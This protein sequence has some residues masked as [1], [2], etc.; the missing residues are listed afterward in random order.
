MAS[1]VPFD[2]HFG[3]QVNK[4]Q[5]RADLH[6]W[7]VLMSQLRGTPTGLTSTPTRLRPS[8]LAAPQACDM[9]TRSLGPLAWPRLTCT[10]ACAPRR[11]STCAVSCVDHATP[12]SGCTGSHTGCTQGA[13]AQ[14]ALP[15]ATSLSASSKCR[16]GR[17]ACDA[18]GLRHEHMPSRHAQAALLV[19]ATTGPV[20]R[21]G[22]R[23]ATQEAPQARGLSNVIVRLQG[24]ESTQAAGA[25]AVT[26][27]KASHAPQ[28][29]ARPCVRCL[30]PLA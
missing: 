17:R 12:T 23:R 22:P 3:H 25:P 16:S 11:H 7:H 14:V 27:S 21:A 13:C 15:V 6:K 10:S 30:R 29:C 4:L 9:S 28:A 19:H 1:C 5:A 8:V 2:Q 20:S 26:N 24:G 18:S